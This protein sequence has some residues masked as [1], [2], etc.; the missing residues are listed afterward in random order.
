M[1]EKNVT[2]TNGSSIPQSY[3]R[4]SIATDKIVLNNQNLKMDILHFKDEML[5]EIKVIKN[6]ITEKYDLSLS[7]MKEKFDKYE[8]RLNNQSERINEI[9]TSIT[10]NDDTIKEIK[11]LID[12]R[13]KIKEQML[14]MNIKLNNIDREAK[15]GIFRIDNIL[16]DSVVYPSVI[17]KVAKFKTFHQ[18]IDYILSQT[19]QNITF[20]EKIV[21][22]INQLKKTIS[23]FDQGFQIFKENMNKEINI[24]IE[25]KLKNIIKETNENLEKSK[26]QINE[27][28][29]E[30]QESVIKFQEKLGEF[31]ELK[32][33]ITQEIKE[34]GKKLKEENDYTLN[35][36]KGYKKEINLIKDRFTQLSEFIK[37]VRF[38]I[39]LGQEVKRR[40]IG[41]ITSKIDF[42]KK[43][44]V[45]DDKYL[46]LYNTKYQNDKDIP[47]FFQNHTNYNNNILKGRITTE[48]DVEKKTTKNVY[49]T[50]KHKHKL[51]DIIHQRLKGE[52]NQE[53][54]FRENMTN[55]T[56]RTNKKNDELFE[57]YESERNNKS[58]DKE[59]KK[60]K[61]FVLRKKINDD[62]EKENNDSDNKIKDN[63]KKDNTPNL[64]E[65]NLK[66]LN[67]LKERK[68]SKNE[69]NNEE[70]F[71]NSNITDNKKL[72]ENIN[73][74]NNKLEQKNKTN[75][76]KETIQERKDIPKI[77]YKILNKNIINQELSKEPTKNVINLDKTKQ[78]KLFNGLNSY[79][80][81]LPFSERIISSKKNSYS[82]DNQR[83]LKSPQ[84]KFTST[85]DDINDK[86]VPKKNSNI[87]FQKKATVKSLT[88]IQSA[89]SLKSQNISSIRPSLKNS[90][91][92]NN[93]NNMDSTDKK[94]FY[95]PKISNNKTTI[96]EDKMVNTN[97]VNNLKKAPI[98]LNKLKNHLNP[99]VAILQHSVEHLF[100]G[101]NEANNL[102]GMVSNLQ[103]YINQ[104]NSYYIN[105]KDI[106]EQQKK[107]TRNSEYFRLKEFINGNI[108][109]DRKLQKSKKNLAEIGFNIK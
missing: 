96:E 47:D 8:S 22:D 48:D 40:E 109:N 97:R 74:I 36:F 81:S 90:N 9:N 102:T 104:Y 42:S 68:T 64:R 56:N 26:K 49:F 1:S 2:S 10:S 24:L 14:T 77:K 101:N 71:E 4:N 78:N 23:S 3:N 11:S 103:K 92:S 98:N 27:Y 100:E 105:K 89:F 43:Q 16:S 17:G 7:F 13:N 99:N 12:F 91:S 106:R 18:M 30:I 21:L 52:K 88:R 34:E 60:G 69:K 83:L 31:D 86:I 82:K 25:V 35:I 94:L 65:L 15:N 44:K 73:P 37:D 54:S 75:N 87:Y 19:S 79:K 33:K 45:S 6:S 53:L 85:D 76:F 107:I 32:N 50:K 39:N 58:M 93:L 20:R 29:K 41:Q 57:G 28:I 55:R 66:I 80:N 70:I 51:N 63:F 67:K 46:N 5:K 72:L 59:I 62:F 95:V 38:K 108:N 84:S 61:H